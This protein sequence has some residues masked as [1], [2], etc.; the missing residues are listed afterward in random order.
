VV[1]WLSPTTEHMPSL[2]D[3]RVVLTV[4]VRR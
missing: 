2:C 3:L 4:A 1:S